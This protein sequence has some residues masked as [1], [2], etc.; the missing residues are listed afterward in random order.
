MWCYGMVGYGNIMDLI[1]LYVKSIMIYGK[2]MVCILTVHRIAL[3]CV[4]VPVDHRGLVYA[5]SVTA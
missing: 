2:S 1:T 4:S 3:A 5:R